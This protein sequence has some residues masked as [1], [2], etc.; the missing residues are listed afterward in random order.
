MEQFII[1]SRADSVE[2]ARSAAVAE[3]VAWQ[4]LGFLNFTRSQAQYEALLEFHAGFQLCLVNVET[5]YVVAAANCVP[6]YLDEIET[7]ES[8]GWDWV[9][10]RAYETRYHCHNVLAGLAVSVPRIHMSQGF[11]R[12]MIGAM[13]A[14]AEFRGLIGPIIPVRPS[15]KNRHPDVPIK[16]YLNWVD[17]LG[18]P[19]DPWLRTHISMGGT[20]VGPCEQ[21]MVVEEPIGFWEAWTDRRYDQSGAFAFAGGLVPVEIDMAKGIGRYSEPNVWF[22]Y[23]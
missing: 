15:L 18:R 21:S 3:Q 7:L 9:V 1:K 10:E 8:N 6:L 16:D 17:A 4:E 14:M 22:R 20:V 12:I 13:K 5:G 19:Y 2:L 23:G 11:A